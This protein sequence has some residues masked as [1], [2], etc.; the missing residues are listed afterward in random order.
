MRVHV[1]LFGPLAEIYGIREEWL[2]LGAAAQAADVYRHYRQRDPRIGQLETALHVAVNQAV[3]TPDHRLAPN[4][5]VALLPPV[6]GGSQDGFDADLIDLVDL[7]L[8][9]HPWRK[10]LTDA[11]E[12]F[13]AMVCF[14]GLVRKEDESGSVIALAFDAYRPMAVS[15]LRD[16]AREAR[17]RWPIQSIVMLHRLGTVPTGEI[18]VVVAVTTGHREEAFAACKFLIDTLKATVPIWKKEIAVLGSRWVEGTLLSA[19]QQV[20]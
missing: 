1:L 10:H 6:C 2:E 7:P 4:D 9:S 20:R 16:L 14:E 13:G 11:S 18:C 17:E 19:P 3:V 15:A 5:E 8:E 12:D